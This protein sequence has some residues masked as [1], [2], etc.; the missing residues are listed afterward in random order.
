MTILAHG[1]IP[2]HHVN[3][4]AVDA[5]FTSSHNHKDDHIHDHGSAG[6]HTHD[7][8]KDHESGNCLLNNLLSNFIFNNRDEINGCAPEIHLIPW[9]TLQ[10]F[11]IQN[12]ILP[13][14]WC[15]ERSY[16]LVQIYTVPDSTH[17]GLRAP[18]IC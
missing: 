11:S 1:L 5:W 10:D 18:P 12:E 3:G 8:D 14:E 17:Y 4:V 6:S 15:T 16:F 13:E 2:H 7:D 9:Y